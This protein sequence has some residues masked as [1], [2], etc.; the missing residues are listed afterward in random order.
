LIGNRLRQPTTAVQLVSLLGQYTLLGYVGQIAVLQ[1]LYMASRT[2]DFGAA[3]SSVAFA[4][5]LLLTVGGIVVVDSLRR[6]SR[7]VD[8]VY[9]LAFA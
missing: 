6:G 5:T 8:S 2:V 9:R 1:V 7:L 3:E 4:A